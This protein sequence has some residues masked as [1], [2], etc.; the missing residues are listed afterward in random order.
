MWDLNVFDIRQDGF[1]S[2]K[3]W[4]GYKHKIWEHKHYRKPEEI[5]RTHLFRP[6][7]LQVKRS[8]GSVWSL[9]HFGYNLDF[10][11]ASNPYVGIVV[12]ALRSVGKIPGY[13]AFQAG[14]YLGR[15][16]RGTDPSVA[17]SVLYDRQFAYFYGLYSQGEVGEQPERAEAWKRS[18]G[19]RLE[20]RCVAM[21]PCMQAVHVRPGL[22][23]D[24]HDLSPYSI[25]RFGIA[26]GIPPVSGRGGAADGSP[27]MLRP[28]RSSRLPTSP[29]AGHTGAARLASP[30]GRRLLRHAGTVAWHPPECAS[31]SAGRCA[32]RCQARSIHR[33]G[34]RIRLVEL[35]NTKLE[36][37]PDLRA[38][39]LGF[40]TTSVWGQV[41][42]ATRRWTVSGGAIRER[43]RRVGPDPAVWEVYGNVRYQQGRWAVLGRVLAGGGWGGGKLR[44]A[45]G[46]FLSL[47]QSVCGSDHHLV[48]LPGG[49]H[50]ARGA[51][52][53]GWCGS[54][55]PG[56]NG[57]HPR[58]PQQRHPHRSA[59]VRRLRSIGGARPLPAV[60]RR[61]GRT[62]APRRV[63]RCALSR[64]DPP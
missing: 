37:R 51:Q 39:T 41:A 64:V 34:R 47:R 2:S 40:S 19:L 23:F 49:R 5:F 13:L 15:P 28:S 62:A 20:L 35:G 7:S 60:E 31:D 26:A 55:G 1:G 32:C 44:R 11:R 16:Y 36:P 4:P 45:G 12:P 58:C 30:P 48:H 42:F 50:S 8:R 43:Y 52:S 38:G 53:R 57:P 3:E 25:G 63:A 46:H 56:G 22:R 6:T 29:C 9:F 17:L 18:L 33:L 14:P 54:A 61:F 10:S 27:V 21:G 59:V 24:T